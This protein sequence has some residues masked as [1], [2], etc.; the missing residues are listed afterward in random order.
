MWWAAGLQEAI[1]MQF[2][3]TIFTLFLL[4]MTMPVGMALRPKE[5]PLAFVEVFFTWPIRLMHVIVYMMGP[6]KE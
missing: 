1:V 5:I 4:W 3:G 6:P 2:A